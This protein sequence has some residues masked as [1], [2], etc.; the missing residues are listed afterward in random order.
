[1]VTRVRASGTWRSSIHCSHATS[2]GTATSIE[3]W[4]GSRRA[5]SPS[6][7]VLASPARLATLTAPRAAAA[8]VVLSACLARPPA[9]WL[10]SLATPFATAR[11]PRR[12]TLLI[13]PSE[14]PPPTPLATFEAVLA[15]AAAPRLAA[16]LA[17]PFVPALGELRLLEVLA[18]LDFFAALG[19]LRFFGELGFFAALEELCFFEELRLAAATCAFDLA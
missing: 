5:R 19:E 16:F 3:R 18:G 14:F 9:T 6:A 11:S 17:L 1:S 4:I 8:A 7:W 15:A 13:G 2:R 12:F 10:A